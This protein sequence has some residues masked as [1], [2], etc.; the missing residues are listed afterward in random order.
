MMKVLVDVKRL[1]GPEL[2]GFIKL[3]NNW[4]LK[5]DVINELE[6][7]DL[8]RPL[9]RRQKEIYRFIKLFCAENGYPPTYK[10]I[11]S[12]FNF[13]SDNSAYDH[14]VALQRK[15]ALR[16]IKGTSRGIKLA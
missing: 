4:G 9:T 10:E 3:L 11:A 1:S 6:T 15:G 13:K 7:P 14:V 5:F 16:I 2:E 8:E 12:K